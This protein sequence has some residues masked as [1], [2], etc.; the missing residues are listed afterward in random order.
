MD[1][2]IEGD[3]CILGHM[4]EE[5]LP[6]HVEFLNDPDVHRYL[7]RRPPFTLDDQ[8]AW[9]K[10]MQDSATDIIFAIL[11]KGMGGDSPIFIGVV[12]LHDIHLTDR[13]ARSGTIIG[14]KRYWGRGIGTEAKLLQLKYAFV[15]LN[16]RWVSSSVAGGNR[17]SLGFLKNAGYR[18]I[19]MN[20]SGRVIDG[21]YHDEVLLKVS[22][23][24]WERRWATYRKHHQSVVYA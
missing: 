13:T 1:S 2:Q 17:G 16:L 4:R 11:A 6:R 24:A 9:L 12:G 20:S 22:K 18:K 5:Y 14:D 10:R 8:E 19:G 15:E 21:E 23:K 7:I 3:L